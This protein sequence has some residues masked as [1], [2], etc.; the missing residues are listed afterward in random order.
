M[1][2]SEHAAGYDLF[3]DLGGTGAAS[4]VPIYPGTRRVISTGISM[5]IP[6]SYYGRV[7]PR[8]GL[9]VKHGLDVLAG[10]VDPDYRG[11]VSVVLVNHG[12]ATFLVT[13]GM[14]IA[15]LVLERVAT[16]II[17]EVSELNAAVRGEAGFGST[18]V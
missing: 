6:L 17:V 15:Q 1:R 2:G 13:H 11:D 5:E 9:A 3:A 10:V 16:P 4:E 8:S 14:R 18:G 7:A 12:Q